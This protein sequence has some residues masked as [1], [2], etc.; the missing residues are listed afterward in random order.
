[1]LQKSVWLSSD[2]MKND[3]YKKC[4]GVWVN[5]H[6]KFFPFKN[7]DWVLFVI[8]G[9]LVLTQPGA[10]DSVTFRNKYIIIKHLLCE[11]AA[12]HTTIRETMKKNCSKTKEK[13]G[14]AAPLGDLLFH[15]GISASVCSPI[16]LRRGNKTVKWKLTKETCWGGK[17]SKSECI[18]FFIAYCFDVRK[19]AGATLSHNS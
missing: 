13:R 18:Q 9:H 2:S 17:S 6:W 3:S 19:S 5:I 11:T 1:M 10:P 4:A 12:P 8:C 15:W 14:E 7:H 16:Y